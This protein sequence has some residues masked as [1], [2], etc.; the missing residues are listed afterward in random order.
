M[1]NELLIIEKNPLI[2]INLMDNEM[3]D[4]F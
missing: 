4:V 3:S 1:E 2:L